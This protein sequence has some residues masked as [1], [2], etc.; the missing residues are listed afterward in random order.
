M[1][2]SS[3]ID[4][5]LLNRPLKLSLKKEHP[6][7]KLRDFFGLICEFIQENLRDI[8]EIT[9][10]IEKIG[11]FYHVSKVEINGEKSLAVLFALSDKVT[12]L[13]REFHLIRKLIKT[14]RKS[15][16]PRPYFIKKLRIKDEKICIVASEWLKDFCEWHI[17]KD[18]D[19]WIWD[20][21]NG[22]FK[23]TRRQKEAIYERCAYILTYYFDPETFSQICLWNHAAGDF[24]V[25]K[26][27]ER[28]EVKLTTV[29]DYRPVVYTERFPVITALLYLLLNMT[30]RMRKDR[31]DGI[32]D[33]VFVNP[34][35]IKPTIVGFLNGLEGL[36]LEGILE[37][38]I[39]K[40]LIALLKS[41][42]FREISEIFF[43]MCNFY[44][45][46]IIPD[47]HTVFL[48]RYLQELL[49]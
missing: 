47:D 24:V 29:R 27:D 9:V 32:G 10:R 28:I 14:R 5:S 46:E 7:L 13:E 37:K 3:K 8:E 40:D 25:K 11:A 41:L 39:K 35:V 4:S 45:E 31:E 23:A 18:R 49:P 26:E 15:F 19:L 21:K 36:C 2:S 12:F 33:L 44:K 42:S 30:L 48:H 20:E 34:Q 16:L 38:G 22:Y 6:W 1:I 43:S 17:G